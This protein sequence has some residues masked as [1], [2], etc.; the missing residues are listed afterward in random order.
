[1][2]KDVYTNVK[3]LSDNI[4]LSI[5]ATISAR[6]AL[7]VLFIISISVMLCCTVCEQINDDDD[8]I[9]LNLF[10]QFTVYEST[11]VISTLYIN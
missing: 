1:V 4:A 3:M 5:L 9:T 2:N 7:L 11:V 10:I 6:R 8:D